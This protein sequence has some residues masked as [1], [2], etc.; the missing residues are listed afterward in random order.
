[1]EIVEEK[2]NNKSHTLTN[3]EIEYRVINNGKLSKKLCKDISQGDILILNNAQI[4]PCDMILI[5]SYDERPLYFQKETLSGRYT[6]EMRR[7]HPNI[8]NNFYKIKNEFI[9][10]FNE[11]LKNKN[12]FHESENNVKE[13]SSKDESDLNNINQNIDYINSIENHRMEQYFEF[14]CKASISGKFYIHSECQD[15]NMYLNLK[16]IFET[17]NNKPYELNNDNLIY[18]GVTLKNSLWVLGIVTSIGKEM[19]AIRGIN[20]DT[21]TW[22]H[23]FRIRKSIFEKQINYYFFILLSILLFLSIIAGLVRMGY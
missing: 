9:S 16:T 20:K 19:K 14:L 21:C 7:I 10:Y 8:Q 15:N 1:M 13:S 5:D 12:L 3:K 17:S 23:Y 2:S 22:S 6:Y 11:F 18:S 4:C